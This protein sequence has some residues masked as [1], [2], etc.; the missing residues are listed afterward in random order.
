MPFSFTISIPTSERDDFVKELMDPHGDPSSRAKMIAM[1]ALA[2][3][4]AERAID[5][6]LDD[7]FMGTASKRYPNGRRRTSAKRK[8]NGLH[9]TKKV[10]P[11]SPSRKI[12]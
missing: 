5:D 10:K 9:S 4:R 12:V 7:E 11:V 2:Q 6:I 8:R 1:E 3:A